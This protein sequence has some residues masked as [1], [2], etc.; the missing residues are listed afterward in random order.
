MDTLFF[1]ISL[2][3]MKEKK[4]NLHQIASVTHP[5]LAVASQAALRALF[6]VHNGLVIVFMAF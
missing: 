1:K 2:P 3:S 4:K 6:R 5:A